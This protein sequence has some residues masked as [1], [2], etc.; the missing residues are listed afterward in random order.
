MTDSIMPLSYS[1]ITTVNNTVFCIWMLLSVD[2]KRSLHKQKKIYNRVK[3]Q[4][5]TR[6]IIVMISQCIH[7][8]NHDV[9]YLKLVY[10]YMSIIPW[11]KNKLK[12]HQATVWLKNIHLTQLSISCCEAPS[13][14][15]HA[16]HPHHPRSNSALL[17][18]RVF[19]TPRGPD[20]T[21]PTLAQTKHSTCF[22]QDPPFSVSAP[23]LY[24]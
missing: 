5:T 18:L 2:L 8:W 13:K 9:A 20:S 12:R 6:L 19:R 3:W 1:M 21:T 22:W 24:P 14:S 17:Y 10:C 7:I 4:L 23:P 11:Q 16:H 15:H